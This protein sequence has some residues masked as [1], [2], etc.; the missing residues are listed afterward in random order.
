[1]LHNK[2]LTIR[3]YVDH[4]MSR[5]VVSDRTSPHEVEKIKKIVS[6]LNT[7]MSNPVRADVPLS[8]CHLTKY[9]TKVD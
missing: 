5:I 9:G 7:L 2:D 3:Q 6:G 8:P 4:Q 1:M